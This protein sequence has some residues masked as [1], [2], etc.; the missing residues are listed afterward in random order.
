MLG[1]RRE[2]KQGGE[3]WKI[4]GERTRKDGKLG[5]IRSW[6]GQDAKEGKREKKRVLKRKKGRELLGRTAI[7]KQ[8]P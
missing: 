2:V 6:E 3:G 4:Y 7:V 5:K 1:G 8:S